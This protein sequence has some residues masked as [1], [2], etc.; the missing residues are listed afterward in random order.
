MGD[1]HA[2]GC[3]AHLPLADNQVKDRNKQSAYDNCGN[4]RQRQELTEHTIVGM[5]VGRRNVTGMGNMLGALLTIQ[6][7]NLFVDVHCRQHHHRQE[8]RQ[9]DAGEALSSPFHFLYDAVRSI[10]FACKINTNISNCYCLPDF[11]VRFYFLFCFFA[12]LYYLCSHENGIYAVYAAAIGSLRVCAVACVSVVAVAHMGQM[13][14]SGLDGLGLWHAV[15]ELG[16]P[17]G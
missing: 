6:G 5:A 11:C 9:Q 8:Y 4:E 14:G 13:V 2:A 7:R 3:M 16:P 10:H 12:R 1:Y 15:R 17:F